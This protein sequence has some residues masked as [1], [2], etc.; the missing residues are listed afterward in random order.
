MKPQRLT[1]LLLVPVSLSQ[2]AGPVQEFIN[3]RCGEEGK[4]VWFYEGSLVD[5]LDG[6]KISSVQGLEVVNR[7]AMNAHD[8]SNLKE[9]FRELQVGKVLDSETQTSSPVGTVGTMLCRKTFCYTDENNELRTTY[10]PRRKRAPKRKIPTQEAM[11][12][13]D[14][15]VSMIEVPNQPNILHTE[16]LHEG[17]SSALGRLSTSTDELENLEIKVFATPRDLTKDIIRAPV[18]GTNTPRRLRLIQFGGSA[19]PTKSRGA[20]EVYRFTSDGCRMRYTRYGEGPVWYGVGR[21]CQLELTGTRIRP[22]DPLPPRLC[23]DLSKTLLRIRGASLEQK[24]RS[25]S[26]LY[27][28]GLTGMNDEDFGNDMSLKHTIQRLRLENKKGRNGWLKRI[29]KAASFL[30]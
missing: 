12:R 26:D 6:S 5:P 28:S 23:A 20:R 24:D 3:R 8:R 11:A 2:G 4:A 9:S 19:A 13:I 29:R 1:L 30:L 15:V 10:I 17:G 16:L 18:D 25:E 14:S 27:G 7:I 21:M 22:E